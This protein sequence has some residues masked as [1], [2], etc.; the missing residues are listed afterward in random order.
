VLA[1]H[2]TQRLPQTRC[3]LCSGTFTYS[4]VGNLTCTSAQN[5]TSTLE[6]TWAGNTHSH[7]TVTNLLP[8]LGSVGGTAG[9]NATITTGRFTGDHI[10][11]A[12][13]R[14]P[15]ALTHCLTT[16]LAP[17][18]IVQWSSSVGGVEDLCTNRD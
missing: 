15:T 13:L 3:L 18:T 11:I 14:D 12:N 7:S 2:R 1:A 10:L 8:T 17:A 9:L 4:L 5:L 16:D 6:V